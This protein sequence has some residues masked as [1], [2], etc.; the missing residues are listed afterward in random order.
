MTHIPPFDDL[1]TKIATF[2][3]TP[4]L[5]TS[6]GPTNDIRNDPIS[7][8]IFQKEEAVLGIRL[9]LLVRRL[10]TEVGNGGF[11][12]GHG[13]L[14]ISLISPHDHSISYFYGPF[15]AARNKKQAD[16]PEG[17]V[18]FNHWGDLILSCIDVRTF[19]YD[20]LSC[21]SRN[22]KNAPFGLV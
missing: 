1:L 15:R 17:I 6:N 16:W 7:I 13:L 18:P 8:D 4:G 22:W 21:L 12:P 2:A 11:G 3:R 20:P 14:T 19:S 5:A 9:P 10:Y